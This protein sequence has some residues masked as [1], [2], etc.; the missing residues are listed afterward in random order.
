MERNENSVLT[1]LRNLKAIEED[2]QKKE[3]EARLARLEAE[4]LA[5]AEA[6]K[7]AL[8]EEERRA[9]AVA[10]AARAAEEARRIEE[11]EAAIRLAQA[12]AA[13]R[14]EAE[15][16]LEVERM[17]LG[18]LEGPGSARSRRAVVVA[19]LGVLLLLGG[20]GA[21]LFAVYL[22]GQDRERAAAERQR[23]KE[24][25]ARAEA[26][27]R[28]LVAR[29]TEQEKRLQGAI[30]NAQTDAEVSRLRAQLEAL[31]KERAAAAGSA[32]GPRPRDPMAIRRPP[33]RTPMEAPAMKPDSD[34]KN[35]ALRG[36]FGDN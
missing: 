9:M 19:L 4:R 22:P 11:R 36:L 12:E 27:R 35:N 23:M 26:D 16:R 13:A 33:P 15:A 31:K 21:Y 25:E 2:R 14:V 17:R 18:H 6:A 34:V 29:L 28:S 20:G 8:M 32:E 10:E 24:L 30:A 5:Q 7:Q 1:S 3:E